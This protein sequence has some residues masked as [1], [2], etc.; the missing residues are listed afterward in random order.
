MPR[1]NLSEIGLATVPHTSTSGT[2]IR[3]RSRIPAIHSI[4]RAAK[5]RMINFLS[6]LLQRRPLQMVSPGDFTC[7]T[8][9]S[10]T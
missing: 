1:Q 7:A 4:S 6:A 10:S 9:H 2:V 3:L 8:A 5:L